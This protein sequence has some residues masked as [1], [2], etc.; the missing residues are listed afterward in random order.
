VS[1]RNILLIIADQHRADTVGFTGH[2]ACKTPHLDRMVREGI[3]FDRA[4]CAAPLCGPSRANIFAGLYAHQARGVLLSDDLGARGEM[5]VPGVVSDMMINDSSLR[6]DPVLTTLLKAEGYYTAY[7]GKW[8]LGADVIENWFD[9][10]WGHENRQYIQWLEENNYPDCWP[11][12][13]NEVRT[14]REPHMSI[15]VTKPNM[16]DPGIA[17]D[18]WIADI[19]IKFLKERPGEKP[20]FVVCGFNGPHPPFKIP[21][22]YYSMYDS[23]PIPE[24]ANFRPGAG[25][26]LCKERS[27]YRTLWKDHGSEWERWKKTVAVYRG[28]ATYIDHQVGRLLDCLEDEGKLDETMVIYCSDHGEMLGQHGLWHKMQA[29]EESLRVPLVIRAPWIASKRRSNAPASLIDLAPTILSAAGITSPSNYEGSDLSVTFD[30][31]DEIP[32]RE[33]VF[34]EHAPLGTFH[35]ETDWRMVTDNRFKYIWN[36]ADRDELYDLLNDPDELSNL[37]ADSKETE[38]QVRLRHELILWMQRTRDPLVIDIES[39]KTS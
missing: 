34:S 18:A 1:K 17:N 11:L 29:Y 23:E 4:V 15:P 39:E 36:R 2:S 26:P 13:D 28:F 20:F 8:H 7:A 22:P 10:C 32:G 37:A 31:G 16:I 38:T 6:E 35:G 30:G 25:E 24:P 21:E 27:F 5:Y 3:S 9:R 12:H 14:K 33:Y 19:A